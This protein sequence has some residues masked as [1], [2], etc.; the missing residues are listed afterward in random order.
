[1]IL[2]YS[3]DEARSLKAYKELPQDA[4]INE[5]DLGTGE[6]EEYGFEFNGDSESDGEGPGVRD[7]NVDDI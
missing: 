2:K 4:K 3:A 1:M 5:T 7:I 6:T